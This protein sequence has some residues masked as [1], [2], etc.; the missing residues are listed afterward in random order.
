MRSKARSVTLEMIGDRIAAK[1]QGRALLVSCGSPQDLHEETSGGG[2][3]STVPPLPAV[4]QLE[5]ISQPTLLA[6]DNLASTGTQGFQ[7][8]VGLYEINSG[9]LFFCLKDDTDGR[10]GKES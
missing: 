4:R 10:D 7:I 2:G 6:Q 3:D 5:Q 8:A 9:G 1:D